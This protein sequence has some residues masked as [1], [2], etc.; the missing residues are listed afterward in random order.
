MYD[1]K[2]KKKIDKELE[3]D[4]KKHEKKKD[5]KEYDSLVQ[6]IDAEFEM[7]RWFIKVKWDEWIVRLRLYNN[8][9]K[10]KLTIGDPLL[11]TIHQTVLASLYN[12]QLM[13]EF[14]GREH[15]DDDIAENLNLL[16][17]YDQDDMEKDILDYEL[18]WDATFF[19]RALC[20]FMEFDR[21]TKTPIPEVIDPLTFYRDPLAVSVAGDRRGRNA[22]KFGGREIRLAK[23]EIQKQIKTFNQLDSIESLKCDNGK[24]SDVDQNRQERMNI[25]GY[26]FMS[27]KMVGDNQNYILHEWFT[28]HNGKPVLVTLANNRKK[29]IRYQPLDFRGFPIIDRNIYPIAHDWD[30]VSIPDLVEDKQRAKATAANLSLDIVK[31]GLYPMYLYNS[32]KIKNKSAISKFEF[33]KFVELDTDPAGA[34]MEMPR[35]NVKQDVDWV[36]TQLDNAAQRATATP[37]LQQ[38]VT[39][40]NRRTATELSLVS[41]NVST[42]YSLAAKIFGWSERRFW[43]QYYTLY[44]KHF[45]EGIDEKVIRISGAMGPDWRP[46]TRE[47][48]ISKV[49]PDIKVESKIISDQRRQVQLQMFGGYMGSLM[50]EETARKRPAIKHLGKLSGLNKDEINRFL[51]KTFDEM[52]AE[53][54]NEKLSKNQKVEI[55]PNQDHLTHLEIHSKASDTPATRAHVKAH[56]M[57]MFLQRERPEL[58]PEKGIP[59]APDPTVAE[60]GGPTPSEMTPDFQNL[61]PELQPV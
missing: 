56:K 18:D 17:E 1:S 34:I 31:S 58:F 9:R 2:P 15:G 28:Y 51:P 55:T 52:E 45:K 50:Q 33:N 20:L 49:D 11:F 61:S 36:M 35:S 4:L 37:E 60:K 6:Q 38:G 19:G 3:K 7:S 47:N 27:R 42:R 44:K 16:A 5:D 30:G 43:R 23:H 57:A 12:D 8:Q 48:I 32:S 21:E 59:G 53:Q 13:V 26:N 22:M 14:L 46:L 24:N 40:A 41:Q 10:D 25:Q 29:V 39:S 54:E